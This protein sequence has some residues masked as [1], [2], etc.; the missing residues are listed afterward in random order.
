MLKHF[1]SV[2]KIARE[3]G[4]AANGAFDAY[5][6]RR[7]VE[8]PQ[9][10]DRI[11]G[12]IEE[13]IRSRRFG[14]YGE[15]FAAEESQITDRILAEIEGSI[16]HRAYNG[17]VWK[18]RTLRTGSGIAAEEK[19]HG[20]DLMG[21]LNI[22]LPGYRVTKGFLAQA[23]RAE[24]NRGFSGRDWNRLTSQCKTMLG[25]TPESFVFVY[26]ISEGIR[27]VPASSVLG[28]ESGNVFDLYDSS[29][30]SFFESHIKCNIGDLRL[31][32]TN[33]ETLEALVDLHV[34][35]VLELA[36]RPIE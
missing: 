33:I 19:R 14:A 24:P 8:E 5:R 26:S 34:E 6:E 7:V 4:D 12:A 20:A 16:S 32:S 10:T 17:V 28:L 36:A 1:R 22:D 11:L 23:K 3:I 35:R 13:R 9:V 2:R 31:N 29:V 15:D 30:S 18:A 27:I 21:V 25:R